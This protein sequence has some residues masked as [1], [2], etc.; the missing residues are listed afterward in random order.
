MGGVLGQFSHFFL[1]R[2]CVC[3]LLTACRWLSASLVSWAT[4]FGVVFSAPH[5]VGGECIVCRCE[6]TAFWTGYWG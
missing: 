6:I 1:V 4:N 3:C 5:Y 2:E